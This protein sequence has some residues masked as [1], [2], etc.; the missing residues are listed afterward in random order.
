MCQRQNRREHYTAI[1]LLRNE[2][3]CSGAYV[4]F[5]CW[6]IDGHRKRAGYLHIIYIDPNREIWMDVF[7][8]PGLPTQGMTAELTAVDQR[9]P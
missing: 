5:L 3:D 8:P 1:R 7:Y 6:I 4:D 9:K 2:F